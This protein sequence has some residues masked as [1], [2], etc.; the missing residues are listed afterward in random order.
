LSGVRVRAWW[1]HCAKTYLPASFGIVV[2][3]MFVARIGQIGR[4]V[5]GL[6]LRRIRHRPSD[7]TGT[8]VL[9]KY[10]SAGTKLTK[11]KRQLPLKTTRLLNIQP[12]PGKARDGPVDTRKRK[13]RKDHLEREFFETPRHKLFSTG[14]PGSR[15]IEPANPLHTSP[16]RRK[17][18]QM[19]RYH[20]LYKRDIHF[21]YALSHIFPREL[22]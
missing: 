14:T 8:K 21:I 19:C 7:R 18:Q 3:G 9:A 10:R 2:R 22:P 16:Q 15:L 20:G 17:P 6:T 1:K 13:P 11:Q 12:P 5:S 4:R